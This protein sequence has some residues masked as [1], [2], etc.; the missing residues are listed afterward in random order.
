MRT[1]GLYVCACNEPCAFQGSGTLA[2]DQAAADDRDADERAQRP[3]QG[4]PRSP[5]TMRRS[6]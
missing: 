4:K 1:L 2:S 3:P 6:V 5:G